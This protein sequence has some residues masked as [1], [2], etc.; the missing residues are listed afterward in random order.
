MKVENYRKIPIPI[1]FITMIGLGFSESL[2]LV[3]LTVTK[4]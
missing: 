2:L 1:E 4:T 3:E